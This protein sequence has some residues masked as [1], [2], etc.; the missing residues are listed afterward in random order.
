MGRYRR[1][2]RSRTP[3]RRQNAQKIWTPS[4]EAF[5]IASAP[6]KGDTYL[7][8]NI[9]PK[10]G[11]VDNH[12][13]LRQRGEFIIDFGS[14]PATAATGWI[15]GIVLPDLV[16][17]NNNPGDKLDNAPNPADG[18]GTDDF[19]LCQP[20]CVIPTTAVTN[21]PIDSKAKRIIDNDKLLSLCIHFTSVGTANTKIALTLRTLFQE[22]IF[23]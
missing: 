1:Y 15:F 17:G 2:S 3:Y 8:S 5:T 16:Y 14:N 18:D 9:A 23:D 7:V 6:A 12:T 11:T 21:L 22:R 20:L 13:L 10:G 4:N 19:P